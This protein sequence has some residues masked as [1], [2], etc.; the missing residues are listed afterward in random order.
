MLSSELWGCD[1]KNRR[2][3]IHIY[4]SFGPSRP[5][6]YRNRVNHHTITCKRS[7]MSKTSLEVHKSRMSDEMQR[8]ALQVALLAVNMH[9]GAS[10]IANYIMTEFDRRHGRSWHC[11]VGNCGYC[12]HSFLSLYGNLH[13]N[14]N[15]HV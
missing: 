5:K 9:E 14:K 2:S 11:I 7:A 8:E 13:V 10:D 15:N 6:Y 4:I 1:V 3:Q 12:V